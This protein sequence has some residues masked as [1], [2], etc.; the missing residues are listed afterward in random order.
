MWG[1]K[2]WSVKYSFVRRLTDTCD[3]ENVSCGEGGRITLLRKLV[4]C[5]RLY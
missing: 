5:D 2:G 1:G 3:F 4:N